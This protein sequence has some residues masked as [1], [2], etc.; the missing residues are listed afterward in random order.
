MVHRH[1]RIHRNIECKVIWGTN[2]AIRD[3]AGSDPYVLHLGIRAQTSVI[4]G[5]LNPVWNEE[6]KFSVPQ[7]YGPLK[8]IMAHY[9]SSQIFVV[10]DHDKCV[11]K[12]DLMGE[13]EIDLQMMINAAAAFGDPELLEDMQIGRGQRRVVTCGEVNR[14]ESLKVQHTESG[15]LELQMEWIPLDM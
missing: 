8:L 4:N 11:S 5:N 2:L 3:M 6:L 10:F 13:A 14:G 1:D 15:E 9:Y 7:Q 12:D